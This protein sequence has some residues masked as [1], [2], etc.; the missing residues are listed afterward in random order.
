MRQ[1]GKTKSYMYRH[2][3]TYEIIQFCLQG[4]EIWLLWRILVFS[5]PVWWPSDRSFIIITW[6][7]I[8]FNCARMDKNSSD[9]WDILHKSVKEPIRLG[10]EYNSFITRNIQKGDPCTVS[11]L[12]NFEVFLIRCSPHK[13]LTYFAIESCDLFPKFWCGFTNL[14]STN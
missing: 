13:P 9:M 6:N 14:L 1:I 2:V 12:A 10:P 7:W 4:I 11:L 5:S 3:W 8:L